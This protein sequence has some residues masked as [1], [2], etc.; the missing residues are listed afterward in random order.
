[1]KR[2][3]KFLLV[4][5]SIV[6]LAVTVAAI[7]LFRP[8]TDGRTP[9]ERRRIA[10]ACLTMLRSSLTNEVEIKPD[11]SRVPEVVRALHPIDIQLAGSDVVVMCAGKPAE[12]HL[13]RRPSEPKTWILYVAGPGYLGH[14][15]ILRMEHD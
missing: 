9:G 8:A 5:C 12:Y 11:D 10:E 3:H 15:E 14:R 4:A 6:L 2:F 1:M 13:S 7:L